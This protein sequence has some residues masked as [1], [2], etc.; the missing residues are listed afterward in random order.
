MTPVDERMWSDRSPST[1]SDNATPPMHASQ[2]ENES[3]GHTLKLGPA[4]PMRTSPGQADSMLVNSPA[5]GRRPSLS[6]PLK[7][8]RLQALARNDSAPD[9]SEVKSEAQFQRLVASFA[10]LPTQPQTPA[11]RDRGRYPEEAADQ[12]D[13]SGDPSDGDD[14]LEPEQDDYPPFAFAEPRSAP[15]AIVNPR[16]PGAS[17]SGSVNGDDSPG[18]GVTAMD[19]DTIP[20][21]LSESPSVSIASLRSTELHQWRYTPPPTATTVVRTN[22]RKYDERFDPYPAS[23]RRAVSPSVSSLHGG[24]TSL[25]PIY[26]PRPRPVPV[27]ASL[28]SSPTVSHSHSSSIRLNSSVASSPTMRASM[29]LASPITRPIRLNSVSRTRPD[30]EREVNGAGDG[31]GGLTLE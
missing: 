21:S 22:K 31:V 14:E 8:K 12:D 7:L 11:V 30:E 4:A 10:A 19:I 23:K 3:E 26:I 20:N 6:G 15:I 1:S 18:G 2:S 16:T 17:V 27:P 5:H 29:G 13:P 9:E 25:S 24:H 28:P